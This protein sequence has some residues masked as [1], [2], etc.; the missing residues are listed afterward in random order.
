MYLWAHYM[1]EHSLLL[2]QVPKTN[3]IKS[4]HSVLK[5]KGATKSTL[6]QFSLLGI[7]VVQNTWGI[8]TG[9]DTIGIRIKISI[10]Q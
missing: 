1:C 3:P 8:D 9:I 10:G 4:W 2:L 6:N 7:R 5:G